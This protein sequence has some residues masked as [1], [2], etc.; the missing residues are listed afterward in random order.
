MDFRE[1]LR[2]LWAGCVYMSH[3]SRGKP[4]QLDQGAVRVAYYETAFGKRR[5]TQAKQNIVNDRSD[6]GAYPKE[7]TFPMVQVHDEQAEVDVGEKQ[8]LGIGDDYGYGLRFL[9]KERSESLENQI[10]KELKKRG[11]TLR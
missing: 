2:E 4:P 10:E 8:W 3:K 9:R 7:P 6:G 11:Y 1:T 5:P